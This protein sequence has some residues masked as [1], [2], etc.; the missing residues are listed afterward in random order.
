MINETK[1]K[2][3]FDKG[4]LFLSTG[5]YSGYF[6]IAPGTAGTVVG[7]F[8]YIVMSRLSPVNYISVIALLTIAGIYLSTESERILA[9]KDPPEVVIDEIIGI[10]LSLFLLPPRAAVIIAGFVIFRVLDIWKPFRLLEKLPGGWGI[11]MDDAAAGMATNLI[12][13]ALLAYKLFPI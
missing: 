6:P 7:I 1:E 5:F 11:V 4:I 12:I 13:Q 2:T 9:K 8:I 3:P 10:L